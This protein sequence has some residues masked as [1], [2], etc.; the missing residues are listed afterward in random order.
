MIILGIIVSLCLPWYLVQQGSQVP[1]PGIICMDGVNIVY[2]HTQMTVSI[3]LL[4]RTFENS[5]LL[6]GTVPGTR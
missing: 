2:L 1:V 6:P 4:V 3:F 5:L